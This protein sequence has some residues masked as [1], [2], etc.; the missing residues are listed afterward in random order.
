MRNVTL[1][2]L[3]AFCLLFT[4][5]FSQN[6]AFPNAIHAK[7][8][9]NDY[10]LLFNNELKVGQGFEF[11]YFRNV[12]PALNVGVP[13]RMGLAKLPGTTG[14]TVTSSFDLVCRLENIKSEKKI[15][16]FAFA[17]AGYVLS[18]F[19]DGHAQ[20]PFGAG[21]NFRV[22]RFA[23]I[24]FQAE[25]RKAL[26]ADRDNL[27]IGLGYVYM[28]N[29]SE[30]PAQKQPMPSNDDDL[31]GIPNDLDK[32]PTEAGTAAALGCPDRDNDGVAD[33]DDLCPDDPGAL[34]TGGCPDYDGDGVADKDDACPTEAGGWNGCPDTDYDGV[35]DKDDKC[36]TEAGL[37][38]NFGCPEAID[39]D[40]DGF[41][42]DVDMCP[43]VAG[44]LKGCPDKD[45][46]GVADNDDKCPD[47]AGVASNSGCPEMKQDT[48][49]D[50]YT[51]DV[52]MCPNTAGILNGC[53]DRDNDGVADKDDKCPDVAGLS[54]NG[55]CPE[56]KKD[57]D[58]DGFTDDVDM[59]PNTA[60]P[61]SGCP[62]RDN[63]GVADMDDKCPEVAGLASNNGCPE[64]KKDTDGDGFTDDVDMCAD[65]AGP[66]KGCP[67]R[68]NDGVADKDDKCP[69]AAG[70]AKNSGCPEVVTEPDKDGDG[71][72]DSIDPCPNKAGTFGG[73]PDT[74][75]DGVADNKDKCPAT[76]GTVANN[77][78]PEVKKE[79][80]ERLAYAAKAVQFETA[81]AILKNESY[82]ILDE[83]VV[84]M[85]DNPDYT[86]AISGYTDDVGSD[87][88]NL[89]LSQ[90]RAKACYDY[91]VFRGI[92]QDRLRHAGFGEARPIATNDTNAGR[93]LNRRVEFELLFN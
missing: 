21:V 83:I 44:T 40:G 43:N 10:G 91:L 37:A 28:L 31:D 18:G 13:I 8:N 74:D 68:D 25:F 67:D 11:A 19:K 4:P 61:V 27:Q 92:K 62:D 45:N 29:K 36:P 65:T 17:G 54:T 84:I 69:D 38:T 86:L 16:P 39:T 5:T 70:T 78:C 15:I 82:S 87:E 49:G 71:V 85:R 76:P 80:T 33:V 52:D 77:G 32:C 73:C 42:D 2:L 66:V 1:L 51:D 14:N 46:D 60:G 30:V 41:A 9:V 55:G 56:A 59:C 72:P 20:L 35:P 50:G 64:A 24:T 93:E 63:D 88:R 6:Q 57:T 3:L 7:L 81:K 47:V 90:D 89:A 23:F 75:G 34:E 53:P 48:D 26:V 12:A 79:V 58:G 22:S